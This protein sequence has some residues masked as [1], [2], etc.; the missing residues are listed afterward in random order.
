MKDHEHMKHSLK[1]CGERTWT[2]LF[3]N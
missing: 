3:D 2:I 1:N